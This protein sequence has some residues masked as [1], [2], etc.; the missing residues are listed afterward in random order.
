MAELLWSFFVVNSN[1]RKVIILISI[2][3]HTE[4]SDLLLS[5]PKIVRINNV[6][7]DNINRLLLIV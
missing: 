7:L 5:A 3:I 1:P 6:K 2:N 4:I